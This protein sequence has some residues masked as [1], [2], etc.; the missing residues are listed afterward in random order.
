MNFNN[1]HIIFMLYSI[2]QHFKTK[3]SSDDLNWYIYIKLL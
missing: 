2:V 1:K 3:E